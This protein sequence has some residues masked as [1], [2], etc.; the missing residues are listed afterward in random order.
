[1]SIA[2]SFTEMKDIPWV[3]NR[4]VVCKYQCSRNFQLLQPI[5]HDYCQRHLAFKGQSA[6]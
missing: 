6:L 5:L 4:H 1:M 2:S 3:S